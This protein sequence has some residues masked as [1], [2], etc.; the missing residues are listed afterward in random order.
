MAMYQTITMLKLIQVCCIRIAIIVVSH[1]P[2]I[3]LISLLEKLVPDEVTA[4]RHQNPNLFRLVEA[5]RKLGHIK[6]T[7]DP[8]G[9]KAAE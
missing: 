1:M 5:Y 8:L 3:F 4:S 7:T 6:A 9:L 2:P